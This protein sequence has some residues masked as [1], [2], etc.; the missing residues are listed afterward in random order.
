[1]ISDVYEHRPG[2]TVIETDNTW[3]TLLTMNTHPLFLDD[4]TQKWIDKKLRPVI[5][6]HDHNDIWPAQIIAQIIEIGLF[7]A[8]IG[9]E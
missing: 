3:F 2:P 6:H 1:M 5:M 4:K 7:G 9:Q 8:T